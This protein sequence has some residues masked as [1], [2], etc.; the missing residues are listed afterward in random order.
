MNQKILIKTTVYRSGHWPSGKK[1]SNI[2]FLSNLQLRKF[3]HKA[4]IAALLGQREVAAAA[5]MK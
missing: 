1:G 4:V 2:R 5:R 3:P